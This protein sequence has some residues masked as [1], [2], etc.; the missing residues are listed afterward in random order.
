MPVPG[1]SNFGRSSIL[2]FRSSVNKQKLREKASEYKII[3]EK[4]PNYNDALEKKMR[5]IDR[6]LERECHNCKNGCKENHIVEL[7]DCMEESDEDKDQ[8]V[9]EPWKN[10]VDTDVL[11]QIIFD[12][13]LGM[14]KREIHFGIIDFITTYSLMKKIEGMIKGVVQD[15]PS[16]CKPPVYAGRFMDCAK[17]VFE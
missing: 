4:N 6:R 14:I 16:A 13:Q 1:G 17:S 5:E 11:E 3:E 12:P 8:S 7:S 2:N 9:D 10:I 15:D